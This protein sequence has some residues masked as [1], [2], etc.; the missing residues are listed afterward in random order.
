MDKEKLQQKRSELRKYLGASNG[1]KLILKYMGNTAYNNNICQCGWQ[2]TD[3]LLGIFKKLPKM[4][5]MIKTGWQTLSDA[6]KHFGQPLSAYVKNLDKASG[7]KLVR[8]SK[9]VVTPI[10]RTKTVSE[11]L[12]I[13]PHYIST[14]ELR[15]KY[16]D[17]PY[18]FLRDEEIPDV[19]FRAWNNVTVRAIDKNVFVTRLKKY[20]RNSGK[21]SKT[22][23]NCKRLNDG[24]SPKGRAN[25]KREQLRDMLGSKYNQ[26]LILSLFEFRSPG[27]HLCKGKEDEVDRVIKAIEK[28]PQ[29]K[30]IP[31]GW[32]PL[33]DAEAHFAIPLIPHIKKLKKNKA[34]KLIRHFDGVV[35]IIV[36][37]ERASKAL[38][39]KPHFVH[40]FEL[41]F[42]HGFPYAISLIRKYLRE[43]NVFERRFKRWDG[44]EIVVF[45]A[46]RAIPFLQSLREMNHRPGVFKGTLLNK[47]KPNKE[48][49]GGWK[50]R[51]GDE[52][53]YSWR[54]RAK[55]YRK[56]HPQQD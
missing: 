27:K 15:V 43:E 17:N 36:N 52:H 14:T 22:N 10:V 7:F 30:E 11:I 3:R 6:E 8:N 31:Q 5:R 26:R 1:A 12:G 56:L 47:Q 38:K 34:F 9:D 50:I 23:N 48:Q 16:K 29:E 24:F 39:I 40:P 35:T 13:S 41:H 53:E 33:T 32:E 28:L 25:R 44:F 49:I 55:Q 18:K 21:R 2:E 45:D 37:I 46:D 54:E 51:V 4:T 19:R 42:V 20:V